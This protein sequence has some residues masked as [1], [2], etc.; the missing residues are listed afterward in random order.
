MLENVFTFVFPLRKIFFFSIFCQL[1]NKRVLLKKNAQGHFSHF[2]MVLKKENH[3][4]LKI[5]SEWR[6]VKTY[7]L[8]CRLKF[9]LW[10]YSFS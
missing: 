5:I 7:K 3:S 9:M 6:V 4:F 8:T 1:G 10:W 2:H